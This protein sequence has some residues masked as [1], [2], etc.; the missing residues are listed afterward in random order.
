M[1]LKEFKKIPKKFGKAFTKSFIKLANCPIFAGALAL[2]T[3]A[4]CLN[5]LYIIVQTKDLI[6][7]VDMKINEYSLELTSIETRIEEVIK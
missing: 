5:S 3:F 6:K 1:Q 7:E 4:F 2:T